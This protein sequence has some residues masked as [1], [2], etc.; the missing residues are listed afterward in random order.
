[1]RVLVLAV[2]LVALS[3][4]VASEDAG[5]RAAKMEAQDDTS[6]RQL[7]TGKSA[8][9]YTQC[10]RNLIYYRQQANAEEQQ[11]Q[12][13]IAEGLEGM[14]RSLKSINPSPQEVNVN[15]TCTFGCR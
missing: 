5:V 4:C 3:G 12:A 2:G 7:T 10:R 11:R 15:V 9:A 13:R 8:D 14:S 1:M 6:C